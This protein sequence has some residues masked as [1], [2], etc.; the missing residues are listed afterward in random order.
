MT[1][2]FAKNIKLVA[3]DDHRIFLEGLKSLFQL[4]PEF[5]LIATCEDG[6]TLLTLIEEH[7]PEIALVD[8]SMPGATAE[9]IVKNVDDSSLDTHLIALTMHQD[10][11]IAEELL[12][13]GFSGYLVKEDA[14]DE[15]TSAINAVINDEQ[16]IS[17]VLL[18]LMKEF[19]EK[20][21]NSKELLTQRE[22]EVLENAAQGHSNKSIA[23]I[24][25]ISERTVRF[26]ISNC[27]V[28]LEA[29]GRSNA[30][31]KAMQLTLIQLN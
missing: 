13:L 24:M 8:L 1:E 17:P 3:A 9:E 10:P 18:R 2:A 23:R 5:D 4:T 16:F 6:D 30:V 11:R 26:H 25:D 21:T 22:I 28:K 31:A 14:F 29:N 7:M 20:A 12:N 27:C 15:L 19:H